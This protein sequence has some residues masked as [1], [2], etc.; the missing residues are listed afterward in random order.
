M[1]L[2]LKST[3]GGRQGGN[4]GGSS[5]GNFNSSSNNMSYNTSPGFG[6][7]N[8]SFNNAGKCSVLPVMY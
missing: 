6:A 7:A 2:F 3:P 5:G 4:F 1:E 8:S